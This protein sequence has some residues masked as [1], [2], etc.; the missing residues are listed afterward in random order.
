MTSR[1][2]ALQQDGFFWRR[3]VFDRKQMQATK[4]LVRAACDEAVVPLGM[5][6][7]PG[8]RM[9]FADDPTAPPELRA[10]MR[11]SAHLGPMRELVGDNC[12]HLYTKA[13]WKDAVVQTGFGWHWDHTYQ[14]PRIDVR[15]QQQL[16]QCSV[17]T[18]AGT[19]V[20]PPSSARG[21][22][23]MTLT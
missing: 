8:A 20:G 12:D 5:L 3:G 9:F 16:L 23:S 14:L 19:G 1:T 18:A 6:P 10:I 7:G 2:Q 22:H 21:S 17:N 13:V 11:A 15:A 4:A